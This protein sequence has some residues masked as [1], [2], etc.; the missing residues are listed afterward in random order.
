MG[1]HNFFFFFKSINYFMLKIQ[2]LDYFKMIAAF[3][4]S[5]AIRQRHHLRISLD[6][7]LR[8]LQMQNL[9][10]QSLHEPVRRVLPE[11]K[12]RGPRLQHVQKSSGR[13]LRLRG[14]FCHEG[15]R[16]SP[17][18]WIGLMRNEMDE[19]NGT[20]TC[21]RFNLDRFKCLRRR[22]TWQEKLYVFYLS[23]R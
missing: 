6:G 2:L 12:P 8:S 7:Q 4:Y 5:K 13:C 1:L 3:A 9:R 20:N 22:Q 17:A 11:G 15:D 18:E 21:S 23:L 19:T 10:N 14:H 16:V